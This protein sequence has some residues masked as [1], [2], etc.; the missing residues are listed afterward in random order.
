MAFSD[1]QE[2]KKIADRVCIMKEKKVVTVDMPSKILKRGHKLIVE[3]K[4]H[5]IN[6]LEFK[7]Y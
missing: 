3:P 6:A 1:L 4:R 7:D 2:V 5:L